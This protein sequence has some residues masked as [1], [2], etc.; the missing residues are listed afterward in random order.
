MGGRTQGRERDR[1]TAAELAAVAAAWAVAVVVL[2]AGFRWWTSLDVWI[3]L[4]AGLAGCTVVVARSP[5][6]S[7]P[8]C[9]TSFAVHEPQGLALHQRERLGD[10]PPLDPQALRGRPDQA[11]VRTH[12]L[13]VWDDGGSFSVG[14]EG[15]AGEVR[16][17]REVRWRTASGEARRFRPDLGWGHNPG[18]HAAPPPNPRM[19]QAEALGLSDDVRWRRIGTPAGPVALRRAMIPHVVAKR[20]APRER[21]ADQ[22]L[23]ALTDPDEVWMTYMDNGQIRMRYLRAEPGDAGGLAVAE[24]TREGLVWWN[25]IPVGEGL[26]SQRVGWLVHA[27][28]RGGAG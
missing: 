28:D 10:L 9:S 21:R 12:Y 14:V 1:W 22:I 4:L 5:R 13:K 24:D 6:A 18:T 25:Y 3:Q 15:R 16:P 20:G 23:P 19:V 2:V 11:E 17:R 27:A 8:P 7:S 26:N